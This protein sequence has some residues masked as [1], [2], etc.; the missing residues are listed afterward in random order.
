MTAVTSPIDLELLEQILEMQLHS[1]LLP[2]LPLQ[3]SCLL[4]DQLLLLIV[5]HPAPHLPHPKQV[6][7]FLRQLLRQENLIIGEQSVLI[8]LREMG[9]HQP[10]AFEKVTIRGNEEQTA[11]ILSFDL[12]KFSL[13]NDLDM[14]MG[15]EIDPKLLEVADFGIESKPGVAKA[16]ETNPWEQPITSGFEVED[17]S[18]ERETHPSG[19]NQQSAEPTPPSAQSVKPTKPNSLFPIFVLGVGTSLVMFCGSLYALTR[20]CALGTCEE[21]GQARQLAQGST[22][23]LRQPLSG[24]SILAAQDQL[25]QSIGLLGSIPPWSPYHTQAQDLRATYQKRAEGLET[26]VAALQSAT[27][28]GYASQNPPLTVAQWQQSQQ[29]WREAITQLESIPAKSDFYTFAQKKLPQY[30]Q[31]L[32]SINFRLDQEQ[33]AQA[34]I[35]SA[36]EV[37][38]IAEQRQTSAISPSNWELVLSTWQTVVDRLQGIPEG[39]TAHGQAQALLGRYSA[40]ISAA[41]DRADREKDASNLYNQGIRSA[42]LAK[43]SQTLDQWSAAVTHWRNALTSIEQVPKDTYHAA[44]AKTLIAPYEEALNLAQDQVETAQ[45]FQQ[46]Q[47]DLAEICA[48]VPAVCEYTIDDQAITVRLSP[49]YMR[50]VTVTAVNAEAKQ[51]VAT[52]ADLFNHILSLEHAFRAISRNTQLPLKVYT[53][54]GAL[55]DTYS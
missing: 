7:R 14:G 22:A 51:D 25:D 27:R 46:A 17:E 49:H 43:E 23:I 26:V 6:F 33:K 21:I 52:K 34:S 15:L 1:E 19:T 11:S 12:G 31:N 47:E 9:Q 32:A 30:Q 54:D 41:R 50:E 55:V 53:P 2:T 8:Y 36:Q 13:A 35:T 37:I 24:Q 10:Y 40:K 39:T 44:K 4:R 20:P 5:Q 48:G 38:K 18:V 42:Q 45:V 28:A 29:L 3:V 16:N